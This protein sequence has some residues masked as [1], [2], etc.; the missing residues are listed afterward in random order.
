MFWDFLSR[1]LSYCSK[2]VVERYVWK[3]L[4]LNQGVWPVVWHRASTNP[5][6]A[7]YLHSQKDS[8]WRVLATQSPHKKIPLGSWHILAYNVLF[9]GCVWKVVNKRVC[10]VWGIWRFCWGRVLFDSFLKVQPE[11]CR[12]CVML[13]VCSC[14]DCMV[15]KSKTYNNIPQTCQ[16]HLV[17]LVNKGRHHLYAHQT[18]AISTKIIKK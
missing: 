8:L 14:C 5:Y 11:G 6:G 9:L 7:L 18:P 17:S 3:K 1:G 4:S 13:D 12:C 15:S 16:S 10:F 2:P